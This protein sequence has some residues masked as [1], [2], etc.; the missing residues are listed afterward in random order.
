MTLRETTTLQESLIR[1]FLA[2]DVD[3]TIQLIAA[4]CEWVIMATGETFRGTD[5]V[6]QLAER[7]VAAR[8]HTPDMHMDFTNRF[9]SEDQM[10]I[11]YAHRGVV[12]ERWPSSHDR[13]P[14]GTSFDI[15][16]C[17]V[18]HVKDGKIDWI[19]EYFDLGQVVEPA[20]ERRLYS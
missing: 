19:H 12:T 17:L 2:D 7:S 20:I 16:I 9:A 4:D 10:C 13:P 8:K 14:V 15:K 11:E 5:E 18:C 6:R 1:A 3:G